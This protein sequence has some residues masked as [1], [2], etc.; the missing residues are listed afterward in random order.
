MCRQVSFGYPLL[1]FYRVLLVLVAT[2]VFAACTTAAPT[3]PPTATLS[4]EARLGKRVFAQ[5][6]GSCH[7]LSADTVIVGP[8]MA[9][10]AT[11]AA[12]RVSH[13]DARRYIY[14]SILNPGDFIVDGFD[15]Q[16]PTNFGKTLT[17]EELDGVV[18]F[19]LTLE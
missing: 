17:G 11:R 9:G 8:S 10:I 13:Q 16:M 5:Q 14:A 15:D 18:A 19:L 2:A 12:D 3:P 7:S 4:P 1:M 6:C